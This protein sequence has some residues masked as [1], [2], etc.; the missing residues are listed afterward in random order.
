M[1][2][3]NYQVADQL[4]PEELAKLVEESVFVDKTSPMTV[5]EWIKLILLLPT[6]IMKIILALLVMG[7]LNLMSQIAVWGIDP[8]QPMYGW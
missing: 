1:A 2:K 8:L 4:S 5:W 7:Q 3:F 6:V